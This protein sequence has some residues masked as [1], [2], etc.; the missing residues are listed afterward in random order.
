MLQVI[1]TL[2]GLIVA[3][4]D[5]EIGSGADIRPMSPPRASAADGRASMNAR[6]H[7]GREP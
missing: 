7:G 6:I 4:I 2:K 1:S 3:A 5:G